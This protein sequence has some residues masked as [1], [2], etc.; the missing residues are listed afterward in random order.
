LLAQDIKVDLA[1]SDT[2]LGLLTGIAFAAFYSLMG[3]PIAR[4]ADRG[5]RVT[6]ISLTTALWSITVA[7]C[8]SAATFVQLMLIRVGVAIG[9]AGCL[10][11]AHSLIADQF[12]RQERPRAIAKY[13]MGGSLSVIAGYFLAGWLNER[14]GWRA[15]FLI[16]GAPGLLLAAAARFTLREP[17]LQYASIRAVEGGDVGEAPRAP[18]SSHLLH[19][20]MTLWRIA[21]FRE[22]LLGYAIIYFF[23]YGIGQWQ[24]AFLMRTYGVQTQDLGTGFAII[25]GAGGMLATYA[26][27]A[28]AARRAANNER[29]QL[30]AIAAAYCCS[31][32][33]SVLVYFSG[34]AITAFAWMGL[35]SLGVAAASGPLF[36]TIQTLVPEDMRATAV[37]IVFLFA[38]LIGMGFGP[39]AVGVMSDAFAASAGNDS[40]RY[41]LLLMCPGYLW[42]AWHVWRGRRTI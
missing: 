25:Y 30:A 37:A 36:A 19:V 40:L 38:N 12:S 27:G 34:N 6:I 21:T 4:W 3:I 18:S 9:E 28:W 39:L 14:F 24:P 15:T 17:R 2:Q 35:G 1:L 7:L 31:G 42:A 23:A 41:A 11:T 13:M 29:L 10:P 20:W 33:L 5:N 8:G 26:G 22:L 32:L 16:L